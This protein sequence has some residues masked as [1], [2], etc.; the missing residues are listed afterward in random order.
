MINVQYWFDK[1][2]KI[3]AFNEDSQDQDPALQNALEKIMYVR[4]PLVTISL[5]GG[6]KPV[7]LNLVTLWNVEFASQTQ[8]NNTDYQFRV[9]FL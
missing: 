5:I 7:E 6:L 2:T 3:I 1:Q 8:N 4:L 9:K